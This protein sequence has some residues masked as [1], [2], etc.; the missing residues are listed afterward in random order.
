MADFPR[1]IEPNVTKPLWLPTGYRSRSHAGFIQLR[2]STQVGWVWEEE[3]SLLAA[4]DVDVQEFLAYLTYAF[5]RQ[6]IFQIDHYL[7]PGSTKTRNG[8]GTP[9][10]SITVDGATQ[11]GDTLNTTGWPISQSNAVRGGDVFRLENRIYRA[12]AAASSDGSGDLALPVSPNVFKSPANSAVITISSVKFDAM[13]WSLPQWPS[14]TAPDFYS[15]SIGF[16]E[17]QP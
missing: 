2:N 5:N 13:I 16:A 7:S 3:Y 6:I 9:A 12:R 10:G 4:R 8:E 11:T 1:T 17:V 15:G 14:N